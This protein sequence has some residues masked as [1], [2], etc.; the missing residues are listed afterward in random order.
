MP[1]WG[2]LIEVISTFPT[3]ISSVASLGIGKP[4]FYHAVDVAVVNSFILYNVLVYQAGQH[5][6]TENDYRD[7][8]GHASFTNCSK[9]WT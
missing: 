5:T 3:T 9:V 2:E 1:P 7:I 4:F 6:L 8:Q